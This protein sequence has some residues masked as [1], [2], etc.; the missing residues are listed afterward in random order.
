MK[1]SVRSITFTRGGAGERVFA[2]FNLSPE[3]REVSFSLARHHGSYKDA[4]TGKAA[5]FAAQTTLALP[6]WGFRIY[7]EDD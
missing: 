6:A 1:T 7:R 2:V 3:P 4:L 5:S